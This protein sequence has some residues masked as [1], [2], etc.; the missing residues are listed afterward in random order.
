MT[1]EGP[2]CLPYDADAACSTCGRFGAYQL[3]DETLCADCHHL[4]GACCAE[5]GG[6]DLRADRAPTRDAP[7]PDHSPPRD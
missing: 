1:R 4:R 7:V 6:N 2:A 5:S 3:D